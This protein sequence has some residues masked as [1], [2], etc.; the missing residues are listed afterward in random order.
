MRLQFKGRLLGS[1]GVETHGG[2][3]LPEL[4]LLHGGDV[5][6]MFV[7]LQDLGVEVLRDALWFVALTQNVLL[8]LSDDD[9][10]IFTAREVA[11]AKFNLRRALTNWLAVE[12]GLTNYQ[13][14][15]RS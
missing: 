15:S 1:I 10:G 6:H 9:G 13:L 7:Q 4:A 3:P 12:G 8:G 2:A 14:S 5:S 11:A